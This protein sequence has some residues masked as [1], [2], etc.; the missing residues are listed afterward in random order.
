MLA[1]EVAKIQTGV[2]ERRNGSWGWA[3][4][5]EVCW[6]W[7]SCILRRLRTTIVLE[8]TTASDCS[9]DWS[10]SDHSNRSWTN[11]AKPWFLF[12]IDPASETLA[13]TSLAAVVKWFS[14]GRWWKPCSYSLATQWRRSCLFSVSPSVFSWS[15]VG[16]SSSS[17]A[18][19]LPWDRCYMINPTHPML[20]TSSASSIGCSR[21]DRL[22]KHLKKCRN[23]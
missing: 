7:W 17:A 15:M 2:W 10:T 4:S 6:R 5:V 1:I 14:V 12:R 22:G 13:I 20:N 3:A 21:D 8:T 23:G 9:G 19:L 16:R 18:F 11:V